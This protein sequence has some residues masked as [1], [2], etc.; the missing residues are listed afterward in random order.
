[1]W[2]FPIYI[3]FIYG[4]P[5][6]ILGLVNLTCVRGWRVNGINLVLFVLGGFIGLFL[7]F[8]LVAMISRSILDATHIQVPTYIGEIFGYVIMACGAE[9]GGAGFVL[10]KY[11]FSGP[12][13]SVRP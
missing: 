6:A 1:M 3:L 2:L 7:L 5:I 12:A 11:K 10:M 4:L 13:S 9:L 8:N